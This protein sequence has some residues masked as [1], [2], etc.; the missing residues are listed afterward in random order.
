M[1][2]KYFEVFL[3]ESPLLKSVYYVVNLTSQA[4]QIIYVI[5]KF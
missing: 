4:I 5:L 3:T 1:I 2:C